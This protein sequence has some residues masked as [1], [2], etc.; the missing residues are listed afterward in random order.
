MTLAAMHAMRT[1]KS[2]VGMASSFTPG[3]VFFWSVSPTRERPISGAEA[4]REVRLGGSGGLGRKPD[5]PLI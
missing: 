2:I 1:E 3:G 4:G 5:A